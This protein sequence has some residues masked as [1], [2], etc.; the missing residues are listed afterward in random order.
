MTYREYWEVCSVEAA[1]KDARQWLTW[2]VYIKVL[3]MRLHFHLRDG[4]P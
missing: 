1:L 3:D 2:N 4:E